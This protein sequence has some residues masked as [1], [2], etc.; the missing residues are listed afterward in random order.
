MQLSGGERQRIALARA[1]LKDAPILILDEPTSSVDINT[2]AAI[3][4]ALE[5]LMH[6]R[7]TFIIAHRVSTLTNCDLFLEIENGRLVDRTSEVPTIV[8]GVLAV[9]GRHAAL[10][11]SKA[12]A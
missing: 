1:F 9:G 8:R 7:T 10:R 3:V 2:E 4:K 11:G 12:D 5:Q 6:G